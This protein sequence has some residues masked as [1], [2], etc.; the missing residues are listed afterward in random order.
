V[1]IK[2]VKI[3]DL[4]A[5][6]YNP[7]RDLQPGDKEYDKLAK[8]IAEF[9]YID[10]VIWNKRSG[11]IVGGHQRLKILKAQGLTEIDVSVVDLDDVKEKAL[12][13]ALNKTGGD[14]DLPKL[15]DLLCE[16]D[17]GDFDIEI[18]GFDNDE[19]ESL[20]VD[21]VG[22]EGL[23][24]DDAVPEVPEVPV[25]KLGDIWLLGQHRVMCGDSSNEV[26]V[27]ESL[28]LGGQADLLFTDPPYGVSY[29]G[30]TKDKLKIKNDAVS[31]TELEQLVGGWFDCAEK[32]SR[33]G[34]YWYATVPPGPLHSVFLL[35]WKKRGILRQGMVW[36]KDSMVLGHS[37]FHYRHEPI[38]FGW[39]PGGERYKSMD[40]TKT[41][42]WQYAR[43]KA[44]REHPTMKPVEMW[45]YG[46]KIHTSFDS[47]MFDPFLGSGTSVIACEKTG[48]RCYGMELDPR[49]C[50]VIINRWQDF[51]GQKATHAE[52]LIDFN[53]IKE[54]SVVVT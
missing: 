30:G 22:N 41:T 8:S 31:E 50:D 46:I 44:S 15:S 28:F 49:Y 34:A 48:R 20:L 14:W 23:T 45:E 43:P 13:L 40:R 27:C 54:V 9:D 18:T 6:A 53:D 38:L 35:D 24:D 47:V 7:R 32:V 37:E 5:A 39:V 16:I 42:V 3:K 2:T 12:N 10:P 52:S 1:E 51:T 25:T 33:S 29:E 4:K 21:R 26:D 11:N 17:T 36:V 19:L